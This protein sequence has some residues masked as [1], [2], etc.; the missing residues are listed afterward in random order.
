MSG[1]I[2]SVRGRRTEDAYH[3]RPVVGRRTEA[4]GR[5]WSFVG[6][7]TNVAEH[8]RSLVGCRSEIVRHMYY[9]RNCPI[10]FLATDCIWLGSC[11]IIRIYTEIES[12][13]SVDPMGYACN[14][15]HAKDFY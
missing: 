14:A 12:A 1:R 5:I 11:W 3:A 8:N 4:A 9:R 15:V 13:Q 6:R 2:R 7:R 10:A